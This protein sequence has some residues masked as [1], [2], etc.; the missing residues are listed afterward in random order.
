MMGE[1]EKHYC[2]ACFSGHYPSLDPAAENGLIY[3]LEAR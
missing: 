3:A 2:D 1:K